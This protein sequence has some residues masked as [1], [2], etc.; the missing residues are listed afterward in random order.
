MPQITD[1]NI[2]QQLEAVPPSGEVTDPDLLKQLS[3]PAPP[4]PAPSTGWEDVGKSARTAL[5]HDLVAGTAMAP[6]GINTLIH[7]AGDWAGLNLQQPSTVNQGVGS[8]RANQQI[9][10]PQAIESWWQ[11]HAPSWAQNYDPQTRAGQFTRTAA[12]FAPS[13]VGGAGAVSTAGKTWGA[14]EAAKEFARQLIGKV[15]VPAAATEAAGAGAKTFIS[16]DAEQY[17]RLLGGVMGAPMST[18]ALPNKAMTWNQRIN[19]ENL[20]PGVQ[21]NLTGRQ[22]KNQT[23]LA[24]GIRTPESDEAAM[25]ELNKNFL[26]VANANKIPGADPEGNI[27]LRGKAGTVVDANTKRIGAAMDDITSRNNFQSDPQTF[28]ELDAAM[29]TYATGVFDPHVKPIVDGL[30]QGITNELGLRGG[31]MS[32]TDYHTWSKQTGTLG[33]SGQ[34]ASDPAAQRAVYG[35]KQ[36]VDQ[37]YERS[38]ARTNP[39][40]SGKLRQASSDW[41]ANLAIEEAL[42]KGGST[43]AQGWIRPDYMQ[44]AARQVYGT[45]N[46]Q[47]NPFELTSRGA[48]AFGIGIDRTK[49]IPTYVDKVLG[50][51]GPLMGGLAAE[52]PAFIGGALAIPFVKH[53]AEAV[54]GT[55]PGRAYSRSQL[56]PQKTLDP[57][58]SAIA[59]MQ[60]NRAGGQPGQQ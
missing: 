16:P 29:N 50:G 40:D 18:L 53:A 4:P 10:D 15:A 22:I 8:T 1:P 26:G 6:A 58:V 52:N 36:A 9:P 43:G 49:P 38:V 44:A 54:M 23:G 33:R 39:A 3:E 11:Q 13:L 27:L 25:G 35:I 19:Y 30:Y 14:V 57:L 21:S 17:G 28:N 51:E 20:P 12:G 47:R 42:D 46:P 32:G 45:A 55:G 7:K 60:F 37:A 5:T 41:R 2:L 34:I 56:M 48:H 31:A 59:A 24:G